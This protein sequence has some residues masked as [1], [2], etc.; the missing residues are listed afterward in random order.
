MKRVAFLASAALIGLALA[1]HACKKDKDPELSASPK[2]LE[3]AAAGETKT[4][5]VKSNV[6]WTVAG[7]AWLTVTPASGKGDGRVSVQAAANTA[8]TARTGEI[9]VGAK[10]ADAVKIAVTQ[11][12]APA[13]VITITAHPAD[14]AFAQGAISGS[15]T[16]AATVTQGATLAYQWF[17]NTAK[18]NTGGTKIEGATSGLM[19]KIEVEIFCIP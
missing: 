13:P 17:S 11:A 10:D 2:S 5:D 18:S 7:E 6:S 16:A 9:T 8:A 14:A 3:F 1:F 19:D 4:F 12:A 15:L